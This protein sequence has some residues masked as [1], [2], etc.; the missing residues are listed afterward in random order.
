MMIRRF[1]AG[2]A[3]AAMLAAGAAAADLTAE[4]I[5]AR[6]MFRTLVSFKTAEGHG[7][8][9]K[10]AAYLAK[11]FKIAGFA[12]ADIEIIPTGET[13]GMVVRYRGDRS[14]EAKPILFLAHMDVVDALPGDWDFD[15]WTLTE[16]DG[17]FYGRGTVDNKYGV[18]TLAQ[19]FIGLKKEGFQPTRD[20][21]I[22]F[23]GDEETGMAT[24]RMLA[25]KFKDAEYAL[26]GDAGGG[27]TP[28]GEDKATAYYIQA[29]EKI[30]ATFEVTAKN[31]GGHSSAPRP[32]NAIYDLASALKKIEAHSFP[33]MW[34][35]VTLKEMAASSEVETGEV[36]AALK[37]FVKKPGDKKA[38]KTLLGVDYLT[39]GLRTTCVAT[40]LKAGH[41][42]NA[43]PQTATATVN[44]RI[45]PGVSVDDVKAE[46]ARVV[47]NPAL[48]FAT[49]GDP[50]ESPASIPTP[51][52][53]AA[54]LVA[55]R[56]QAPVAQVI[57]Y[58][59]AGGTDGMHFRRA[60]VPT[61]GVGPMFTTDDD[62]TGIHGKN[63]SMATDVFY[64]GL[65]HWPALI[66]EL[67]GRPEAE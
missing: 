61:F 24:T 40:M 48:E 2:T 29:A 33:V 58:M 3:M 26:N 16:K 1:L 14:S 62:V 45:F 66:R 12:D 13:A 32:D 15:P 39:N 50:V 63:E 21:I 17:R 25:E 64:N 49:L 18:L 59:E 22:V 51:E 4:E 34:N 31:D 9:P 38:A 57:S 11:E 47:E 8:V 20:L 67:A 35:D 37:A 7:E 27:F 53:E 44:C 6:E 42:E 56:A 28:M 19:A 65:K 55:A 5:Q 30:Y 60:G 54:V 36:A 10:M 46:L 41:A 52:L 23:T 43:L